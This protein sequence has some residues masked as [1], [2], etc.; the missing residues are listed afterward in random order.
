MQRHVTSRN[1]PHGAQILLKPSAGTF[2]TYSVG[3]DLHIGIF[4]RKN[5]VY[6]FCQSGVVKE[7][8]NTWAASLAILRLRDNYSFKLSSFL[9]HPYTQ[10]KY[11]KMN[12]SMEH[13]NCFDFVV[14]YLNHSR[15][16]S[17]YISSK[18]EFVEKF[19]MNELI[20][21]LRMIKM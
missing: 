8:I 17:F 7:D 1:N 21:H 6:S 11:N 2:S 14:D 3:D 5:A 20:Q 10:R 15:C 13:R 19:V 18:R 12:Y 9:G 16:L 4:D